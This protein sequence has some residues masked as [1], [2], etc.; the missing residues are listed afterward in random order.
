MPKRSESAAQIEEDTGS[1]YEAILDA[2]VHH[3]AGL[4]D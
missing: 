3:D 4:A 2:I 1:V